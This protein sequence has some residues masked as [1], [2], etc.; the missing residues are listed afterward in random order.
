MVNPSDVDGVDRAV[1]PFV[2]KVCASFPDTAKR[3]LNG[4]EDLA[5]QLAQEGLAATAL[6]NGLLCGADPARA[7]AIGDRLGAEQLEA[8]LRTWLAR[9]AQPFSAADRPAGSR[10]DLAILPAEFALPRSWTGPRAAGSSSRRSSGR[11]WTSGAR[12]RLR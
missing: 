6:D 3:C 8:R 5:R 10:Y 7:Q 4:H 9:L 11:T 12:T 2:L 1:G